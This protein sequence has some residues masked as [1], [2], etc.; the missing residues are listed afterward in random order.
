M[1]V[2]SITL[3]APEVVEVIRDLDGET[4]LPRTLASWAATDVAVPS[5]WPR[6][7]GRY[8]PR[9]YTLPDVARVRLIVRLRG[10]G[11]SLQRVRSILASIDATN[12]DLFTR[13]TTATLVIEGWRGVIVKRPGKADREL[14]SGQQ[15]LD[16][17]ECVEGNL[18][19]V[20]RIRTG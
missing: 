5:F 2:E 20:E 18:Q 10:A 8:N 4:L 16:L 6:K 3:T 9:L 17:S 14:P 12:P 1:P 11:I 15:R 7:R 19:A 13:R